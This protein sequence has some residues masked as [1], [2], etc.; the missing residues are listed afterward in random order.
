MVGAALVARRY[1]IAAER[2]SLEQVAR[3]LAAVEGPR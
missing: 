1:G 3:P 2:Q